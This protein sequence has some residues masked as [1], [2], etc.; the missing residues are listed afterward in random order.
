MKVIVFY[1]LNAKSS[2]IKT[3]VAFNEEFW[4]PLA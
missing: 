4:G 2:Q 3:A 1:S